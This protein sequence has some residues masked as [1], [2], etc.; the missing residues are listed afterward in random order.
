[1]THQPT[2]KVRRG[3]QALGLIAAGLLLVG[4]I[5]GTASAAEPD[6][7]VG[8]GAGWLDAQ[9]AISNLEQVAHRDKPAGFV[10]PANPGNGAYYNSDLAFGGKY[11]F[12]GNYSGF[13]ILD[14]STPGDPT[15]VTSVVCPGGQGDLSVY[16]NL[17]FMSV[18]ETRGR[19]DCGTNPNVG[20]RFQGVRV[21]DISDVRN[22]VQVAGVQLCRG[23]HTH[24]VVT[25]PND[26]NNVYV[27]VSGTTSVRPVTTMEGCNNNA[28]DGE[29]PSRW[30]IDVIKVPLAAPQDA[31]V[32]NQPR[33]FRDPNTGRIDGLQNGPLTP[34][35]PSGATWSPTPNTNAC[36]DITAYPEIGLAAG[37]CQGNGI[38]I[39]IS[40]PANP[41]RIHEVSDP[42]FAY[43][44]SAT[45]NNDGTKVI[46]T[47]EWGGGSGARCRDTD[48]PEWGANAIFD[49]V[50]RKMKFASYYK[51]PVPQALQENCVAHNGS[52]IPVPGRDIMM[53]AWYQGGISVFDFTDS[54]NPR[55][56]AYFD[57]GP[58]NPTSLVLGG[59]WSAYWYNGNL[60]GNEIARGFDVFALTPSAH[61]S[62]AEIAAAG[63][64]KLGGFNAQGQP[65][66][67]WTPTFAVARAYY[68]QLVRANA[69]DQP[70]AA[71]VDK[72]LLRAEEFAAGGKRFA[73]EAQLRAI[74][75]RLDAAPHQ[76]LQAAVLDLAGTFNPKVS[77]TVGPAE[78]TGS[79]GWYT[80]DVTLTFTGLIAGLWTGQYSLDEGATWIDV[81][82]NGVATISSEVKGSV[83][84]RAIDGAGNTSKESSLWLKVDKTAPGVD[85]SG[86]T[87]GASYG[88]SGTVTVDWAIADAASGPGI[89]PDSGLL[90][91][92]RVTRGTTIAL[93]SLPLGGHTFVVTA[94]DKAGNTT[95]K[96]IA[97]TTTTSFADLRAL[98]DGYRS[99]GTVSASNADKLTTSLGKASAA[100]TS[101]Q[102]AEA[103][104]HLTAF[105]NQAGTLNAAGART[106]LVRDAQALIGQIGG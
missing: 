1:M 60:Y 18:E 11:A 10:D 24:T 19:V 90:D 17:L 41:Q 74:A 12:S 91:G 33:L 77:A 37:A 7:R 64:V 57:R 68:D 48:L 29:N 43:W 98:V 20:T 6:P 103:V 100:A 70:L 3:R 58:V 93:S 65:K 81:P 31:A 40:D 73:A 92:K 36:H 16:G 105:L 89:N 14:V 28:A 97:F 63:Q 30:R 79:N 47:D 84:Y 95:T 104:E 27:Y 75:N 46:F 86:L 4:T 78:P 88:D 85:V 26:A 49:I 101:G 23:S 55:E 54:K 66:I 44:H 59:F 25:D 51:L 80:S 94:K 83:R 52:L 42:N 50:D 96:S 87:D 21:F 15:L 13:N 34:R 39:D 32:V 5:P 72:F 69:I 67:T 22:P 99:A 102:S 82:G 2:T 61:L 71:E 56:I 45:F 106:L 76:K 38:L 53:Q 35:H 62:A 9:S 8:L